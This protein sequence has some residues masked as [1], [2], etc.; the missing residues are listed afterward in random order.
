MLSGK[1][2]VCSGRVH[3]EQS[4]VATFEF[5]DYAWKCN[6]CGK[7]HCSECEYESDGDTISVTDCGRFDE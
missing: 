7:F 1:R 4:E 6:I 5:A 3:Y 2:I